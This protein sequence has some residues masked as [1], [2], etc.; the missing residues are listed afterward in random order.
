MT[1]E[2][3][4]RAYKDFR[5][6]EKNYVAQEGKNHSSTSTKNVRERATAL[7]NRLLIKNP[8]LADLQDNKKENENGKPE[9]SE[10]GETD[11]EQPTKELTP[12]QKAAITKTK[13]KKA[14]EEAEKTTAP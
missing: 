14:A 7:A 8:E 10:S 6:A 2:N 11:Q 12:A 1:K 3:R 4:E 5:N 9:E 13:N